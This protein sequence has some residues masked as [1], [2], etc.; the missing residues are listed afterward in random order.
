MAARLTA[1]ATAFPPPPLPLRNAEMAAP[2]PL[3]GM[4]TPQNLIQ[5]QHVACVCLAGTTRTR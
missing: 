3:T 5:S 2:V 1:M 4:A